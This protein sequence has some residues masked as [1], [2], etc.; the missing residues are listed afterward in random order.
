M[1]N[2]DAYTGGREGNRYS[3]WRVIGNIPGVK[4]LVLTALV[5]GGAAGCGFGKREPFTSQGNIFGRT[6]TVDIRSA[7]SVTEGQDGEGP[8]DIEV[9]DI[10]TETEK[11]TPPTYGM[12]K[13]SEGRELYGGPR[14]DTLG[15]DPEREDTRNEFELFYG[16]HPA[17]GKA[18]PK[19]KKQFNDLGYEKG[20]GSAAEQEREAAERFEKRQ[21]GNLEKAAQQGIGKESD[22][23]LEKP[24]A[25]ERPPTIGPKAEESWKDMFTNPLK[26]IG[27]YFWDRDEVA[28]G[29]VEK[30]G[31]SW[32][33][34]YMPKFSIPNFSEFFKPL[35]FNDKKWCGEHPTE[36]KESLAAFM[37]YDPTGGNPNG[38]NGP[39]G[40]GGTGGSGGNTGGGGHGGGAG[41][42][43]R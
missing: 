4:P 35:K 41:A 27:N 18:L 19:W 15:L 26:K 1:D 22:L 3:G 34:K 43:A 38:G 28:V 25:F 13:V 24:P 40:K 29:A 23:I 33:D 8:G 11:A 31:E 42:G 14:D 37:N 20:T 5:L 30:P 6:F 17:K 12:G 7:E 39:D 21:T 32:M 36:C 9:N 10:R 2:N 16:D